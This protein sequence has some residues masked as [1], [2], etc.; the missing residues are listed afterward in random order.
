[1]TLDQRVARLN[2]IRSREKDLK[3]SLQ[4]EQRHERK[5][6]SG[7]EASNWLTALLLK[8]YGFTLTKSESRDGLCIRYNIEAKNTPIFCP[9]VETFALSHALNLC[10]G[11]YTHMRRNKIREAFPNIMHDVCYDVEVELTLQLLQSESFIHKTCNTEENA[12]QDI[13]WCGLWWS[14]FSRYF[15]VK[16]FNQVES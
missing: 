4:A 2:T 13:D 14:R 10:E 12:R 11:G 16:I 15:D 8:R 1:M 7:K 9:C 5:M 6:C 3:E